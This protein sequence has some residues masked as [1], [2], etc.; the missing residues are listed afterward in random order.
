VVESEM[1]RILWAQVK[2]MNYN[3]YR[4]LS[5]QVNLQNDTGR[6]AREALDQAG[7]PT[8]TLSQQLARKQGLSR[9][10]EAETI[11][12]FT[13]GLTGA[14][15]ALG[16]FRK[17]LNGLL[18]LGPVGEAVGL[19]SGFTGGMPAIP[20]LSKIPGL[21]DGPSSLSSYSTNFGASS[22]AAAAKPGFGSGG[23]TARGGGGIQAVSLGSAAGVG[24]RYSLGAVKP[25]VA[26]AASI[27]G[28]KFGISSIGGV[29]SRPNPSDHPKG[30]A[31]DFMCSK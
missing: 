29:G 7:I 23:L 20:G 8:N 16:R 21:G 30:L 15:T 10:T 4:N 28:P 24:N 18:G 9:D 13:S 25:W 27:I 17:M 12:G 14:T 2:G 5:N 31:L 26:K 6:A 11:R 22:G 19:F 1:R 3:E